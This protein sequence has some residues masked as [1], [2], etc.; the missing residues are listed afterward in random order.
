VTVNHL[1]VGSIPTRAATL[2]PRT[3]MKF[4]GLFYGVEFSRLV[5]A[6][7]LRE[8]R[9]WILFV[10]RSTPWLLPRESSAS[11]LRRLWWFFMLGRP[12]SRKAA[13]G[14]RG[15]FG[16]APKH[17]LGPKGLLF[18]S[19]LC[20]SGKKICGCALRRAKRLRDKNLF[21][22]ISALGAGELGGL[23]LGK[24]RQGNRQNFSAR[25]ANQR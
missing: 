10:P 19:G 18:G 21:S 22:G 7:P 9:D 2:A 24:I 23:S 4:L 16:A 20:G 6:W 13:T 5:T 25:R 12:D 8:L 14:G 15:L 3:Y 11:L 17:G 1:V